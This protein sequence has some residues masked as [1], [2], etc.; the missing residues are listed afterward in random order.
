MAHILIKRREN[1]DDILAEILGE[2]GFAQDTREQM[3][4][5]E[6]RQWLASVDTLAAF[7]SIMGDHQ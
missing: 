5:D 4:A 3:R 2:I 7:A 6:E 1:P